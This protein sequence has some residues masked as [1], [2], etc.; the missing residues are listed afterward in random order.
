MSAIPSRVPLRSLLT[1]LFTEKR[2][3]WTATV[4]VCVPD[5]HGMLSITTLADPAFSGLDDHGH[6]ATLRRSTD[7]ASLGERLLTS[8]DHRRRIT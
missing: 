2:W 4:N 7:V 3:G 8:L 6:P 5:V 1:R